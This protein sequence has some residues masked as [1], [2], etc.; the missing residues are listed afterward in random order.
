MAQGLRQVAVVKPSVTL[1]FLTGLA[2]EPPRALAPDVR[3]PPVADPRL[4]QA[5]ANGRATKTPLSDF[6]RN[7]HQMVFITLRE[8]VVEAWA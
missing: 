1:L 8:Q 7:I 3:L 5:A 6:C 4:S 2:Q